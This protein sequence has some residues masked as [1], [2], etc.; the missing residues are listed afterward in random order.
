MWYD[1]SM[2]TKT[3]IPE[4]RSTTS[5]PVTTMEEL[6]V[7]NGEEREVL[8]R[9]LRESEARVRAGEAADYDP[10]SLKQRLLR[11]YRGTKR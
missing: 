8:L 4:R 9:T 5:V 6:P 2:S 7:L 11:I 10:E 1:I 3:S